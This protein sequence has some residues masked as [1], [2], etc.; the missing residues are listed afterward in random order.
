[1]SE[2]SGK[3]IL[4]EDNTSGVALANEPNL[5]QNMGD[6]AF[7][8]FGNNYAM[9]CAQSQEGTNLCQKYHGYHCDSL[10]KLKHTST[11]SNQ[12]C[13]MYCVCIDIAPKP[14]CVYF[15]SGGA[16]CLRDEGDWVEYP[17]ELTPWLA[18]WFT[19]DGIPATSNDTWTQYQLD[20][21]TY[22]KRYIL[23]EGV[24]FAQDDIPELQAKPAGPAPLLTQQSAAMRPYPGRWVSKIFRALRKLHG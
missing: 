9:V 10:G 8:Q 22:V 6:V 14:S 21:P 4:S 7:P 5:V 18:E 24:P 11:A 23:P 20:R 1:M 3:E 12:G 2:R 15:K 19:V 17:E 13:E 16:T